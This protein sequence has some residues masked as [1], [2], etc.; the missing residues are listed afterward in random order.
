MPYRDTND[1]NIQKR[2]SIIVILTGGCHYDI[3]GRLLPGNIIF[4]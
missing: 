2:T 1:N 3:V 4:S